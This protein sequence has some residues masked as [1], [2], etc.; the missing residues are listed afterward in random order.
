MAILQNGDAFGELSLLENKPRAAT[1]YCDS[2]SYFLVL[3]KVAFDRIIATKAKRQFIHLLEK[4]RD[5]SILKELSIN[6]VKVL[7][8]TMERISFCYGDYLYKYHEKSDAIYFIAEGEF[9]LQ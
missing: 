2:D 5:N 3:D 8:L 7:F 4:L 9:K 6:S 1:I